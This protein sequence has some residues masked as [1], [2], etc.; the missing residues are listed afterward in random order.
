MQ[1]VQRLVAS[2]NEDPVFIIEA[3]E[4]KET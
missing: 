4:V 1:V 3:T 2:A